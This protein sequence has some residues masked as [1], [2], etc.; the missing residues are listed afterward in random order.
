M[1]NGAGG[2]HL[3]QLG[4]VVHLRHNFRGC[5]FSPGGGDTLQLRSKGRRTGLQKEKRSG[6]H[7]QAKGQIGGGDGEEQR[8]EAPG[9]S[10]AL[11]VFLHRHFY[12][13]GSGEPL[14]S[15]FFLFRFYY[16]RNPLK[17]Q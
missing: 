11:L 2:N 10:A 13:Q 14:L 15:F 5:G 9:L 3:C 1:E 7:Q 16:E 12:L 17:S 8:T 4:K 6:D